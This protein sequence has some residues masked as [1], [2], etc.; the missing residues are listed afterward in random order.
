VLNGISRRGEAYQQCNSTG[1]SDKAQRIVIVS[2]EEL[3]AGWDA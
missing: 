1:H 3:N 2:E